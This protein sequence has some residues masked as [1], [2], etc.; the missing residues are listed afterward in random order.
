MQVESTDTDTAPTAQQAFTRRLRLECGGQQLAATAILRSKQ[1]STLCSGDPGRLRILRATRLRTV[2]AALF[3]PTHFTLHIAATTSDARRYVNGLAHRLL[4]SADHAGCTGALAYLAH[5]DLSP[6]A[7]AHP[8]DPFAAPPAKPTEN[9]PGRAYALIYASRRVFASA[10]AES[11][12]Q[13]V[14]HL[15]KTPRQL[16]PLAH[17]PGGAPCGPRALAETRFLAQLAGRRGEHM[18]LQRT[19]STEN[20]MRASDLGQRRASN[21]LG[22]AGPLQQPPLLPRRPHR[23]RMTLTDIELMMRQQTLAGPQAAAEEGGVAARQP[24]PAVEQRNKRVAKQLII[25]SLKERGIGRSHRDFAALWS[26]IYRSLRF[27]LRDTLALREYAPREL[28]AESDK[29][30][31]FYCST[32]I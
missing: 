19:L 14:V 23:G 15:L 25:S 28:K 5:I 2:P 13:L 10:P 12:W 6:P 24:D 29:H 31:A 9:I 20:I 17:A 26:Q 16:E 32:S 21:A 11:P 4:P 3:Q 22:T 18:R 27:A 30:A 1:A 7:A 8:A